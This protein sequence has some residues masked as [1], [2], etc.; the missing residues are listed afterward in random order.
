MDGGSIDA[1]P[2]LRAK[3]PPD[4]ETFM[5]YRYHVPPDDLRPGALG[6]PCRVR[7]VIAPKYEAGAATT[8]EAMSRAEA[9]MTLAENSFNFK[10]FGAVAVDSLRGALAGVKCYRLRIGRLDEGIRK[11]LDVV[12]EEANALSTP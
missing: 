2:G 3:L 5:R 1:I 6:R 12:S 10:R 9:L 4:H 11:V 7:Y 8:L